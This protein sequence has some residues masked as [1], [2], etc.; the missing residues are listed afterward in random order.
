MLSLFIYFIEIVLNRVLSKAFHH[1]KMTAFHLHL[2][3]FRRIRS[4]FDH[5]N[6]FSEHNGKYIY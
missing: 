1:H 3:D 5:P 4:A 6:H 2:T